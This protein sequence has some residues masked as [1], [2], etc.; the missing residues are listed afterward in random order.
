MEE[1]LK[2]FEDRFDNNLTRQEIMFKY[3]LQ[4]SRVRGIIELK[5]VDARKQHLRYLEL[6]K[7]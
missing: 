4:E 3:N 2:I 5:T 1:H 7:V 6:K